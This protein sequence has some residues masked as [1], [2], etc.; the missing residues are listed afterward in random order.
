M[1]F[2]SNSLKILILVLFSLLKLFLTQFMLLRSIMV[3]SFF[4]WGTSKLIFYQKKICFVI[5]VY[6]SYVFY[7]TH[8]LWNVPV[9][10]GDISRLT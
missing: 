2:V 6:I 9:L 1:K 10:R 5:F 4:F 3:L 8:I 7:P